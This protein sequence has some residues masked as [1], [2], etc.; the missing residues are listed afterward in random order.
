MAYLAEGPAESHLFYSPINLLPASFSPDEKQRLTDAYRG[1][2][3]DNIISVFGR[4]H[5]FLLDEYS[6]A[7]RETDGIS[8][9]PNVQAHYDMQRRD[10]T[11]TPLTSRETLELAYRE[12]NKSG[13]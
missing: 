10:Y 12:S 1:M 4:F 7:S 2:I 8:A 9:I 13:E 5:Q 6:P 3:E 11:T